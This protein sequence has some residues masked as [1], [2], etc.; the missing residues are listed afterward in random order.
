MGEESISYENND[1]TVVNEVYF[2]STKLL[3]FWPHSWIYGM[4]QGLQTRGYLM[5]LSLGFKPYAGKPNRIGTSID[6]ECGSSRSNKNVNV[7]SRIGVNE[8]GNER[9]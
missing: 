1:E 7:L 5:D 3:H 8:N 4:I 2:C 6:S 9:Q